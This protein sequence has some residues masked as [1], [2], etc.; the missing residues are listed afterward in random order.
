L[1]EPILEKLSE[2]MA[3][4]NGAKDMDNFKFVE[5]VYKT[6]PPKTEGPAEPPTDPEEPNTLSKKQLIKVIQRYHSDKNITWGDEWRVL[7][8]EIS[9]C[10]TAR[11]N[12]MKGA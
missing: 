3:K 4:L 2:D 5:F 1:R 7:S 12:I 9:K 8:E 10:F 11:Y 6:W